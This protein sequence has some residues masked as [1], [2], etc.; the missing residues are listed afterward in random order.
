MAKKIKFNQVRKN[1][2]DENNT[3]VKVPKNAEDYTDANIETNFADKDTWSFLFKT[4][5]KEENFKMRVLT[6]QKSETVEEKIEFTRK[7]LDTILD[8]ITDWQNVKVSDVL[9]AYEDTSE[10]GE[11]D[12]L[13]FSGEALTAFIGKNF[14]T[15]EVIIQSI[16]RTV[17]KAKDELKKN[18]KT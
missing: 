6:E 3:W 11:K 16:V 13:E 8:N 5:N 10:D 9:D 2:D 12:D 15:M 17:A 14:W 7:Q 18:K 4:F 1:F